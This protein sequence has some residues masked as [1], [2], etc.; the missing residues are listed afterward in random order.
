[1]NDLVSVFD[2]LHL[3][4]RGQGDA[5]F[6][7][8]L[9]GRLQE[10]LPQSGVFC[11]SLDKLAEGATRFHYQQVIAKKPTDRTKEGYRSRHIDEVSLPNL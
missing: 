9:L 2:N 5:G 7:Q 3:K 1:M 11:C 4:A 8:D 10:A 6:S